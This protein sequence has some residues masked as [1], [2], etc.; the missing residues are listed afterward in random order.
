MHGQCTQGARG[1]G[2]LARPGRGCYDPRQTLHSGAPRAETPS[3][4]APGPQGR[5]GR[6]VSAHKV[7]PSIQLEKVRGQLACHFGS[8]SA[9]REA[10]TRGRQPGPWL[11]LWVARPCHPAEPGPEEGLDAPARSQHRCPC[12]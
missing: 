10:G 1:Q 12:R 3:G 6:V 5:G 11:G 9:S 7:T 4:A 2:L 8:Q